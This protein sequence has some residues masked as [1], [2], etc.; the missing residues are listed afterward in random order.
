MRIWQGTFA[1]T[2]LP[3]LGRLRGLL[4]EHTEHPWSSFLTIT[5]TLWRYEVKALSSHFQTVS[6]RLASLRSESGPPPPASAVVFGGNKHQ[7]TK[8][9]RRNRKT[10]NEVKKPSEIGHEAGGLRKI[11]GFTRFSNGD[12]DTISISCDAYHDSMLAVE[13][14]LQNRPF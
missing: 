8:P 13:Q 3:R 5:T 7:S 6:W 9:V 2:I 4:T 11:S 10:G 12:F 1:A 14:S